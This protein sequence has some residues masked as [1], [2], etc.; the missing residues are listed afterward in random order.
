VYYASKS[1][2]FGTAFAKTVLAALKTAPANPLINTGKVRL[3]HDPA[4]NPIP[5]STVAALVAQ[6]ASFSGYTAGGIAVALSA[7][8]NL[9]TQVDGVLTSAL[10]LAVTASPFVADVAYGWWIDDGT[11]VIAGEAFAGGVNVGFNGPGDFL[12]L[13]VFLPYVLHQAT[14]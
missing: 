3:S 4:F 11:N 5:A 6:E 2:V 13:E 1:V 8:L 12:D 9:T 7:P 10:F 14:A